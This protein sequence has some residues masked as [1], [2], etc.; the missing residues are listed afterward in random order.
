MAERIFSRQEIY[1]TIL[2]YTHRPRLQN[3]Y[4]V[5]HWWDL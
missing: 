2:V 1:Q 5:R 4:E 3:A